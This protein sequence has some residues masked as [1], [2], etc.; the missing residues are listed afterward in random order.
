MIQVSLRVFPLGIFLYG[1]AADPVL[2]QVP[3]NAVPST[4]NQDVVCAEAV[5]PSDLIVELRDLYN[6]GDWYA[7]QLKTRDLLK[8][9]RFKDDKDLGLTEVASK[10][11]D[12]TTNYVFVVLATT[13]TA[14]DPMVLRYL[15]TD[16][17]PRPFTNRL[18]GVEPELIDVK[19]PVT[20]RPHVFQVL[21][22]PIRGAV[23]STAFVSTEQP[24][25]LEAQVPDFV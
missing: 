15:V 17:A 13:N 19:Q 5:K 25:P 10:G 23:L 21:L 9:C 22:S 2:A 12:L 1:F 18:P 3:G 4:D 24:S 14:G 16:P 20:A 6:K 7:L 8:A 11:L